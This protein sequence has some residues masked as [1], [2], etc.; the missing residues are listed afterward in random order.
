MRSK[1]CDTPEAVEL[2]LMPTFRPDYPHLRFF[3][4]RKNNVHLYEVVP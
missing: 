2:Q 1:P 4:K 3:T